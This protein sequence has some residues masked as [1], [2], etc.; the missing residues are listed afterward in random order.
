MIIAFEKESPAVEP[1]RE[2]PSPPG[3]S[4]DQRRFNS[5]V[6]RVSQ[7]LLGGF[8]VGRTWQSSFSPK[9]RIPEDLPETNQLARAFLAPVV[10]AS[11]PST[12]NIGHATGR[13]LLVQIKFKSLFPDAEASWARARLIL[14]AHLPGQ[15]I[16]EP[17]ES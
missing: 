17:A 6:G 16:H 10:R 3:D 14:I 13:A 9:T 15:L 4:Y 1:L 11:I 5:S 8:P 7:V 2:L 12:R